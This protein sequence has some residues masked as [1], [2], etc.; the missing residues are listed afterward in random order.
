VPEAIHY[1]RV[2]RG[3]SSDGSLLDDRFSV[4]NEG[5]AAPVRRDPACFLD[6]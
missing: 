3:A 2:K 6:Q 1:Q 5:A 4:E